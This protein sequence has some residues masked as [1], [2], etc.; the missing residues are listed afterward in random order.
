MELQKSENSWSLSSAL[1]FDAW[2]A[3]YF[4]HRYSIKFLKTKCIQ[5]LLNLTNAFWKDL[6]LYWLNLTLN[7]SQVLVLFRQ[8]LNHCINFIKSKFTIPTHVEETLEQPIILNPHTKPNFISNNPY[9]YS[10]PPKIYSVDFFN[11]VSFSTQHL[12]RN[13]IIIPNDLKHQIRRET[14][15]KFPLKIFCF[16]NS[17]TRKKRTCK[18]L[19]NKEIDFTLQSDNT[20]H[21]PFKFISWLNFIGGYQ[22]LRTGT[23][24]KIFMD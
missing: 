20:K 9:F 12:E 21:K 19:S 6:M 8:L 14:P 16:N 18:K 23:W 2:S 15:Q 5:R 3:R 11:Q 7:S 22:N 24:G 10:I 1:Y 4:R 17:S 13:W